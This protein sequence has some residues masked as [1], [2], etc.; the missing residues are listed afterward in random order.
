MHS[1]SMILL[2]PW[3]GGCM[4]S[5]ECPSPQIQDIIIQRKGSVLA[6]DGSRS[7]DTLQRTRSQPQQQQ[8][9]QHALKTA[10]VLEAPRPPWDWSLK[11]R[12]LFYSQQ[13]FV[14]CR[15]AIM[16][17]AAAGERLTAPCC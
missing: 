6:P 11:T 17:P 12:A 13:P 10:R 7:R 4:L 2:L 15:D 5:V 9:Q 8:Q 3:H 16:A 14:V 1:R